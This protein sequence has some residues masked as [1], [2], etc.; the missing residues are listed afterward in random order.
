MFRHRATRLGSLCA[1]LALIR[2]AGEQGVRG[3]L[4]PLRSELPGLVA[5]LVGDTTARRALRRPMKRAGRA[6]GQRTRPAPLNSH[7]DKHSS[8]R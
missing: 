2:D 6:M 8:S 3:G 7:S 5:F 4:V 1:R